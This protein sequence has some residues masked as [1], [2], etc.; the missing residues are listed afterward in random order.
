MMH[1]F[2]NMQSDRQELTFKD[3]DP[4]IVSKVSRNI[5]LIGTRTSEGRYNNYAYLISDQCP[6]HITLAARGNVRTFRGPLPRQMNDC[7]EAISMFNQTVPVDNRAGMFKQFPVIA[8]RESLVNALIHFDPSLKTD[9]NVVMRD[10]RVVITSPG[11]M[12]PVTRNQRMGEFMRTMGYASLRGNGAT[13]IRESY[14]GTGVVPM[15]KNDKCQFQVILPSI[16]SETVCP[17]VDASIIV[18]CL[19]GR[20]GMS[21]SEL[22]S[23]TLLTRYELQKMLRDLE[24]KGHL[25]TLGSGSSKMVFLSDPQGRG[26]LGSAS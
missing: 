23:K 18:K 26:L 14:D 13:K 9:I 12:V 1:N 2:E 16:E 5:A 7:M 17:H 19:I 10:D 11:N 25:F 15:I 8:I 20:P 21:V 24:D 6:W 3:L 4:V 22:S